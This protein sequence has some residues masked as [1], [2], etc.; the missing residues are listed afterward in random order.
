MVHPYTAS[1]RCST[2]LS[3]PLMQRFPPGRSHSVRTVC[4]YSASSVSA[5]TNAP[6]FAEDI[7]HP[8]EGI[9]FRCPRPSMGSGTWA[10]RMSQRT[11]SSSLIWAN[12]DSSVSEHYPIRRSTNSGQT[13]ASRK[14]HITTLSFVFAQIICVRK[15][16]ILRGATAS[17]NMIEPPLGGSIFLSI[18]KLFSN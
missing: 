1:T 14:R 11:C 7:S 15:Q 17:L 3:T 18:Y 5:T 4:R 12:L 10:L 6:L 2:I 13:W 8:S 9:D 16:I